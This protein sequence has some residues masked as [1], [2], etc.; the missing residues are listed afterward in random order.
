MGEGC[1]G[2]YK[3]SWKGKHTLIIIFYYVYNYAAIEEYEEQAFH[4]FSFITLINLIN[5]QFF[6]NLFFSKAVFYFCFVSI[7]K[8]SCLC[9]IYWKA[10]P[11][12]AD[13]ECHCR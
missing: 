11:F 12:C 3:K 9:P 6:W 10:H 8:A 7:W 1:V 13:L 5:L 4:V 2:G